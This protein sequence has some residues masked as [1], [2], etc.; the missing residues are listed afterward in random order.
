M[1]DCSPMKY[2][3]IRP[4]R[5]NEHILFIFLIVLPMLFV[6]VPHRGMAEPAVDCEGSAKA[7]RLQGIP[8]TCENGQIVCNQSSSGSSS[9]RGLSSENRMKLQVMESV[10]DAATNSFIR[11]V[12]GPSPEERAKEAQRQLDLDRKQK[13]RET[14]LESERQKNFDVKKNQLMGSLKGVSAETMGL[15]TDFDED[16][17]SSKRVDLTLVNER[18]EFEKMNAEWMKKQKKLIEERLQTPNTYADA[19]YK[20]LKANIPPPPWI[21]INEL[22]PGDVLLF[23]G[24]AISYVDNKIS[25]GNAASPAAHT[26]IYLKDV[27]GHKLFLDNQPNEGPH[28]ISG[29]EFLRLYG[30]RGA[31][32]AKLAQPLNEKEG[33]ALFSAALGMAQKNNK[34]LVNKDTWFGKYLLADTNYGVWGD[35]NVVCSEADWAVINAS[36]RTIPH[37]DNMLKLAL[38]LNFSPSDFYSSPYFL[39]TRFQ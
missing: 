25:G 31:D 22:R 15:K 12:N 37:T 6:A 10:T 28:I 29:E 21:R 2:T 23:K 20:S 3:K 16:T 7:Y 36:G 26:V 34:Q 19:V 30:S 4:V 13:E 5:L 24:K 35:N 33:R 11:W 32:V 17:R 9:K 39:V 27:N 8:C 14:F 38:G 1:R 18:D